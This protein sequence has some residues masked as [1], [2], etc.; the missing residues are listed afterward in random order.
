MGTLCA[1]PLPAPCAGVRGRAAPARP[2]PGL[3]LAEF[4]DGR[5]ARTRDA[6]SH[7]RVDSSVTRSRVF[8]RVI[9]AGRWQSVPLA[10]LRALLNSLRARGGRAEQP[11]HVLLISSAKKN[12]R[13]WLLVWRL[14]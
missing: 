10:L 7:I 4:A 13:A 1:L 11:K 12:V 8:E 6:S 9:D 3:P 5:V 14:D 2:P